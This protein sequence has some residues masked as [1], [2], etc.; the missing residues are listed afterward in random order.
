GY[1]DND[2]KSQTPEIYLG[3]ETFRAIF[4]HLIAEGDYSGETVCRNKNGDELNIELAVF[5]M[6]SGLGE[7]LCY[8]T[9]ERDITAR[10]R[11][12][13]KLAQLLLRERAARADAEKAN[14]LKDEFLATLSHEL[15]TPL[16]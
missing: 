10:K 5:T 16:N 6:R 1:T 3:K 15:R 9:I 7:P 13:E 14:R 4:Q 11:T 12:E 2:L 8:V